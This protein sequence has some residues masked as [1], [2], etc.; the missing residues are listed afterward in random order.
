MHVGDH[1]T[2]RSLHY[3]FRWG[4]CYNAVT[5]SPSCSQGPATLFRDQL[6]NQFYFEDSYQFC[7]L[8][9]ENRLLRLK[10]KSFVNLQPTE[11]QMFKGSFH[12]SVSAIIRPSFLEL[13]TE[14][15]IQFERKNSYGCLG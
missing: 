7:N 12:V 15:S 3:Y 9:E 13:L 5:A 1:W 10:W 2:N 14:L 6:Y 11:E 8:P 4:S